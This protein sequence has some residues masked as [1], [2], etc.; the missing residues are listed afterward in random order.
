[1][2]D[3]LLEL[4]E[5]EDV[6]NEIFKES[7]FVELGV[8]SGKLGMQTQYVAH[9]VHGLGSCPNLSGGLRIIDD[10]SNYHMIKIHK[11]DVDCLVERI[12]EVREEK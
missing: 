9:Y 2:V 10:I 8:V 6:P 4:D 7:E 11:D 12:R 3:R 5:G 1:M